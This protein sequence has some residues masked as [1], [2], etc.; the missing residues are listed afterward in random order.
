[1]CASCPS[2]LEPLRMMIFVCNF[3]TTFTSSCKYIYQKVNNSQEEML[4]K[5]SHIGCSTKKNQC[6][7][8]TN[9]MWHIYIQVH[10]SVQFRITAAVYKYKEHSRASCIGGSDKCCTRSCAAWSTTC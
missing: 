4:Y 8:T 3:T 9:S 5:N 10:A 6:M 2:L 1:M 7:A